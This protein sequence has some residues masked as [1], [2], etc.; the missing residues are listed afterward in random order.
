MR[1]LPL[2]HAWERMVNH[3][4]TMLIEQRAPLNVSKVT[5][6]LV[7]RQTHVS[8]TKRGHLLLRPV[9]VCSLSRRG[10]ITYQGH[11]TTISPQNTLKTLFRPSRVFFRSLEIHSKRRYRICFYL[12][13]LGTLDAIYR[14]PNVRIFSDSYLNHFF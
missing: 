9:K 3:R 7:A 4:L 13:I 5:I 14:F 2:V 12:V 6:E 11:P 8:W 10:A 1:I